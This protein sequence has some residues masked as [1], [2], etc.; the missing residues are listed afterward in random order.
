MVLQE[1]MTELKGLLQPRAAQSRAW[2]PNE[3][4]AVS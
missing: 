1:K 2:F 4:A 3:T